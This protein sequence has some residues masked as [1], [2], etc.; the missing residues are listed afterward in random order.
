V[1]EGGDGAGRGGR[2]YS[3]S[4]GSYSYS[5]GDQPGDAGPER[6]RNEA[7]FMMLLKH[8]LIWLAYAS[9]V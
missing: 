3:Y 4:A 7:W 5:A 2:S 8:V 9:R 1:G 6:R